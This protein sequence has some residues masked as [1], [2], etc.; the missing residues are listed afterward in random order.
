MPMKIFDIHVHIYPDKIAERASASVGEFYD[1]FPIQGNGRLDSCL[2][3]IEAA[4]ITRFAAHSVALTP[5]HVCKVN[6]FILE[7][8]AQAPEKIVPFAT[9]HPDMENL[10]WTSRA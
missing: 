7:A 9:L 1:G 2:A 6:D 5:Q 3:R 4:G 10:R 8:Y